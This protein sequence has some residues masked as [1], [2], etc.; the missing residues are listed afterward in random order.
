MLNYKQLY[1]RLFNAITDALTEMEKQNSG[2]AV[3]ILQ[4]AQQQAEEAYISL[5]AG[6]HAE[7]MGLAGSLLEFFTDSEQ[8][9]DEQEQMDS[10]TQKCGE[11][12][13]KFHQTYHA[14]LE[15]LEPEPAREVKELIE[16]KD[17][18]AVL[19]SKRYFT[20][21][22]RAAVKLLSDAYQAE[23]GQ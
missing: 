9:P 11:Q 10:I 7:S 17:L 1:L 5:D 20:E 3:D 16:Q 8:R 19:E 6:E 23:N 4:K 15:R 13:E 18:I 22:F 2:H 21:G 12:K 14:L